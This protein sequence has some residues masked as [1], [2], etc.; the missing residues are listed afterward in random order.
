MIFRVRLSELGGETEV[1]DEI[2]SELSALRKEYADVERQTAA[3]IVAEPTPIISTTAEGTE[4]R[5]MIAKANVGTIFDDL[6]SHRATSGVE[7][8]LQTH[9][10]LEGNQIP[11]DLLRGNLEERAVTPAPANVGEVQQTIV[12]YVFPQ[13]AAAFLGVDMPTVPV[14]EAVYPVLTKELDVRTPAEN[15]DADETTG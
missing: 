1:T 3:L 5:A 10:G 8:E 4:Y 9:L 7:A 12:P 6:L 15:A 11:L 13:S 2:R 14:G